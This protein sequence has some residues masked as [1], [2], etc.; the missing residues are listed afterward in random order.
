MDIPT[1][2]LGQDEKGN[3]V[4]QLAG[5]VELLHEECFT[6]PGLSVPAWNYIT[7]SNKI[8]YRPNFCGIETEKN[9]RP[10]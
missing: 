2:L 10:N 4:Y 6:G 5:S 9:K 7:T 1:E 8:T 3:F